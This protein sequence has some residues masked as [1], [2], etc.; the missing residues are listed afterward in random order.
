MSDKIIVTMASICKK[1]SADTGVSRAK[2]SEVIQLVF[3]QIE[4]SVKADSEVRV[5]SFGTFKL[6][7]R[8]SRP[9]RNPSTGEALIIAPSE[10]VAFRASKGKKAANIEE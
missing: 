6:R 8:L 5:R 3:D 1:V 2:V 4:A 10:R 7:K 9:W